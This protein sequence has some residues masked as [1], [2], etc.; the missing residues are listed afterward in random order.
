MRIS[1]KINN[2]IFLGQLPDPTNGPGEAFVFII[3]FFA[4]PFSPGNGISE[5]PLSLR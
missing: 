5:F 1:V 4:D 3:P 2:G